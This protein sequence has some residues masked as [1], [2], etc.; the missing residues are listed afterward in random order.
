ML[1]DTMAREKRPFVPAN[2]DRV[3]M[4]VCGPTVYA[5][6]HIGNARSAIVFDVLFR[7]LRNQYAAVVYAR[8]YT[9]IDDKIMDRAAAIE[10]PIDDLTDSVIATYEDDLNSIN[11]LEP[12]IKPRATQT[13]PAII[14]MIGALIQ[15][16]H[17]YV[18][19]DH[20]FFDVSSHKH[21]GE[22]SGQ[23]LSALRPGARVAV[24]AI[25]RNPEDFVLW[26]P[27]TTLQPGWQSPWGYGRPGWHIECS[28]M[29]SAHLGI[30]IDIHGGGNDLVFPHHEAEIAQS[31]CA[32]AGAPLARYWVHNGMVTVDGA[33]M[34]KSLGNIVTVPEVVAKQPGEVLRYLLLSAHYRQPVDFSWA[35]LAESRQALDRLYRAAEKLSGFETQTIIADALLLETLFDDLNTPEALAHLHNM[36]TLILTQDDPDILSVLKSDFAILTSILGIVQQSTESWFQNHSD[37]A[38]IEQLVAERE[39]FRSTKNWKKADEIRISLLAKGI[40]V[41]DTPDGPF[42]RVQP[43]PPA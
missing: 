13:I 41:E 31:E 14:S 19:E 21:H 5:G 8:N 12:T 15:S 32:H 20:V 11:V 10:V 29:I 9:D 27:S 33:K 40:L 43:C 1:Y 25:K 42:W 26:K 37:A 38:D 4:Y 36:A 6:P 17:A 2:P 7:L 30:T 24:S 16:D 23:E 18:S 3:T 22:L 35:K 28:A 34:S 39:F